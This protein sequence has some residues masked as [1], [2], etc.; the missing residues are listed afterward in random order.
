[1]T[2]PSASVRIRV[3]F[4]VMIFLPATTLDWSCVIAGDVIA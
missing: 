3:R 1:V 4:E 2:K